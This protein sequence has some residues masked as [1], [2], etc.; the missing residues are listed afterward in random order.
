MGVN[1]G[2]SH[3]GAWGGAAADGVL[4]YGAEEDI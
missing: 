3:W 2:L 4:E 1:L